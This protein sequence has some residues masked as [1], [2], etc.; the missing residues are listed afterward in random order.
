MSRADS[1]NSCSPSF[2]ST[3]SFVIEYR[4]LGRAGH[5]SFGRSADIAGCK[6]ST[7]NTPK[8]SGI[9]LTSRSVAET[10]R[11]YSTS[12]SGSRKNLDSSFIRSCPFAARSASCALRYRRAGLFA[13]DGP[14][15]R[16]VAGLSGLL[17]ASASAGKGVATCE[18]RFCARLNCKCS[19]RAWEQTNDVSPAKAIL[20]RVY[21]A[22][23]ARG[24]LAS[25]HI[26]DK[27]ESCQ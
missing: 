16:F 26:Y 11:W 5:V 6:S 1:N 18:S 4:H 23:F 2:F 13:A 20:H 19:F 17:C 9:G 21:A 15:W 10:R 8:S 27:D 14:A 22:H 24:G 7:C 12:S 25:C 3:S